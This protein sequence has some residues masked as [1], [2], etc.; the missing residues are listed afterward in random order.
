MCAYVGEEEGGIYD[1]WKGGPLKLI[2]LKVI[3]KTKFEKKMVNSADDKLMIFF[4]QK[5]SFDILCKLSCMECQSLF[6]GHSFFKMSSAEMFAQ[7][8][9]LQ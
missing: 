2:V 9:K 5:I 4:V 1:G 8:A 6:S 3:T 7:H